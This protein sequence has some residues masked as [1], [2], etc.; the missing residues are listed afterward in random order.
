MFMRI[1]MPMSISMTSISVPA[2]F[3]FYFS[4]YK[5]H[6]PMDRNILAVFLWYLMA[7]FLGHL[8]SNLLGNLLATLLWNLCAF[9]IGHLDLFLVTF[10]LWDILAVLLWLFLCHFFTVLFWHLLA[11]RF[12]IPIVGWFI[13]T[14]LDVCGGTVVFI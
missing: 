10:F 5:L 3:L 1:S 4:W 14:L 13:I 2:Y 7:V 9:F 11:F 12:P 8:Y 6:L